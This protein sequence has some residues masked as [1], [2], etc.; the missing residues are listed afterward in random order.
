MVP[1]DAMRR[2]HGFPFHLNVQHFRLVACPPLGW[3]DCFAFQFWSA[4]HWFSPVLIDWF[5]FRSALLFEFGMRQASVFGDVLH[6]AFALIL[7]ELMALLF[8]L[9]ARVVMFND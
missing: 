9:I 3:C 6:R 2:R 1:R 7:G 5:R 4:F 8:V